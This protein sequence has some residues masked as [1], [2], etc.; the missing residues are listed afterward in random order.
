[1]VPVFCTSSL[2]CCVR[3]FAYWRSVRQKSPGYG[4]TCHED[5]QRNGA[6]RHFTFSQFRIIEPH[7]GPQV[8]GPAW[9]CG[10]SPD[11]PVPPCWWSTYNTDKEEGG[12]PTVNPL[13]VCVCVVTSVLPL[14]VYLWVRIICMVM[15]IC[16]FLLLLHWWNVFLWRSPEQLQRPTLCFTTLELNPSLQSCSH[17]TAHFLQAK[18]ISEHANA[19]S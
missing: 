18:S 7:V 4:L 5:R 14:C 17:R 12:G 11:Q 8:E 15:Q 19:V 3:A 6:Q 1:M 2:R 13:C 10:G 9:L 16:R